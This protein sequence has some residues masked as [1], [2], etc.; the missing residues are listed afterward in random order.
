MS[1]LVQSLAL[2]DQALQDTLA[3]VDQ[4]LQD[5]PA[6]LLNQVPLTVQ[7]FKYRTRLSTNSHRLWQIHAGVVRT[8]TWTEEGVRSLVGVLARFSIREI[9]GFSQHHPSNL[10]FA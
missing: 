7:R 4:A 1:L 10:R 3:L 2:V 8:S 5:S 9:L 6:F